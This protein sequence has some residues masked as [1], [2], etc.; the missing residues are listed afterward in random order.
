MSK[1]DT[2]MDVQDATQKKLETRMEQIAQNSQ[3]A[4][5]NLEVQVGQLAKVV[6]ERQQGSLPSKIEINPRINAWQFP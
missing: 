2:R 5:H 3:A 6:Q 1:I 4:I